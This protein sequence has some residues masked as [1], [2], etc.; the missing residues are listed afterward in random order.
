MDKWKTGDQVIKKITATDEIVR[1]IARISGD[2][3]PVHLDDRYAEKTVF[4]KRIAHGLFCLNG[5]SMVIGNHIPGIGSILLSQTFRYKKP[6][7]IGDEIQVIVKI[8]DIEK[9]KGIYEL[10]TFCLNQG[11]EVVLEGISKVKWRPQ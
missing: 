3:N 7:Y 4:G 11:Q 1:E 5:I 9:A 8:K 2:I 10:E 6:V